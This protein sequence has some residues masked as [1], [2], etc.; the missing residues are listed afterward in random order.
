M[1]LIVICL[2]VS[3]IVLSACTFTLEDSTIEQQAEVAAR[4]AEV[5]PFDLEE[6]THIFE[7]ID[8]GG[9]QQVI[10]N[11]SADVEQIALIREHL[12]EEAARFAAGDFHDPMMIHG[13]QMAGLHDLMMNAHK[14]QIEYSD[15][16]DGAQILYTTDDPELV[17]A[18]HLWF[19][20]QLA[21][22]GHHA[23]DW[24]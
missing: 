12:T 11:D 5:M 4:G 13:E 23:T 9:R 21:D 22:H 19:E 6:T 8:N 16:S 7:V 2:L 24:R 10:A 1:K 14:M 3:A 17:Q 15:L 18:I 20:A